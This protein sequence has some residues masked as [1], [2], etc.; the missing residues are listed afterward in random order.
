MLGPTGSLARI[1]NPVRVHLAFE[2]TQERGPGG[3]GVGCRVGDP[4]VQV[5]GRHPGP[6]HP[7]GRRGRRRHVTLPPFSRTRV[8]RATS[9]PPPSRDSVS[10]H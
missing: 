5:V 6:Q 4:G 9:A 10:A 3:C 7:P 8:S 1:E 2:P